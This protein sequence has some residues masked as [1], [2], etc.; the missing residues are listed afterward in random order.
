[1]PLTFSSRRITRHSGQTEVF[2]ISETRKS[3][4][5]SLF[6]VPMHDISGIPRLC[7]SMANDSFA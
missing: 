6:P 4:G 5:S 3:V 2:V 7:D 1:M